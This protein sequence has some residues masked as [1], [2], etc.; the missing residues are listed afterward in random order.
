MYICVLC[1][2]V[3]V[4]M[5]YMYC[6]CVV[7]MRRCIRVPMSYHHLNPLSPRLLVSASL[8]D[9]FSC[10]IPLLHFLYRGHNTKGLYRR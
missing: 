6:T 1:L 10:V 8:F 7:H 9:S 5:C 3:C 4:Y 2:Y